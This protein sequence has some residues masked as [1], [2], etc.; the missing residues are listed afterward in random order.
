VHGIGIAKAQWQYFD[1][2]VKELRLKWAQSLIMQSPLWKQGQ[3]W[4]TI[5]MAQQVTNDC[6]PL[7][8]T[9]TVSYQPGYIH[10]TLR[11]QSHEHLNSND[12]SL[13]NPHDATEV[14]KAARKFACKTVTKG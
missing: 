5:T 6:G 10:W 12:V 14:G 8:G 2:K 3:T 4:E 1:I 11:M 9:I 13:M 7:L